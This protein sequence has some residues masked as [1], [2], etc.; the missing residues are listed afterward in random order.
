MAFALSI[1]TNINYNYLATLSGD[2]VY[3]ISP[4][5]AK[6]C[7]NYDYIFIYVVKYHMVFTAPI[8]TKFSFFI[9]NYYT[10]FPENSTKVLVADGGSYSDGRAETNGR[11]LHIWLSCF[12]C[13]ERLNVD[14]VAVMCVIFF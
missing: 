8:G 9:K 1:F 13:K 12:L 7:R 11:G 3:R 5:S 10:E 4:E 6:K 2:P 14:T